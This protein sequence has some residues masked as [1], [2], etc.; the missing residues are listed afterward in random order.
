MATLEPLSVAIRVAASAHSGQKDKLGKPFIGHPLRVM[1]AG[2]TT[3]EQIVGVLHDTIED[4][5]V[6]SEYLMQLFPDHIVL[7]VEALT[8]RLL[9]DD[10]TRD[11]YYGRVMQNALAH[12]VKINDV[13]DNLGRLD[14]LDEETGTRLL[15]KYT[16]ALHVLTGLAGAVCNTGGA[17][18]EM[19]TYGPGCLLGTG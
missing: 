13:L 2:A 14:G 9:R 16:H 4:T 10:E 3:D 12:R 15:E 6:S 7:A 11:E 18:S 1:L 17:C 19:H 8:F 5:Y